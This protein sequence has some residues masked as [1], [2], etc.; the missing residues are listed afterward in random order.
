MLLY[1]GCG[2]KALSATL[3]HHSAAF[4]LSVYTHLMPTA[5]DRM[6]DAVT[7]AWSLASDGPA[8]AQDGAK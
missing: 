3:G 1:H 5:D 4:A 6:R 8:T 7:A 2:I